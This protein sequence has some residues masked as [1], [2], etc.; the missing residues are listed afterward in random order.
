M[1]PW[2]PSHPG[3]R[4]P[5]ALEVHHP[6][7]HGHDGNR[8]L[9]SL[10]RFTVSRCEKQPRS[11]KMPKAAIN[12]RCSRWVFAQPSDA[13]ASSPLRNIAVNTPALQILEI[14]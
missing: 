11:P 4:V 6:R 3:L 12:H 10:D 7:I 2:A 5:K 13:Q 8:A 14:I 1:R 9:A